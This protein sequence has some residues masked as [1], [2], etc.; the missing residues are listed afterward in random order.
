MDEITKEIKCADDRH[1][2]VC[3]GEIATVMK[4][5]PLDSGNDTFNVFYAV[6]KAIRAELDRRL[7]TED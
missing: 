2:W 5:Y 7:V 6:F 1:L 3:L 4:K